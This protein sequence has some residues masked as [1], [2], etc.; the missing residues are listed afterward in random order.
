MHLIPHFAQLH[1]NPIIQM[2]YLKNGDQRVFLT[3]LDVFQILELI[4]LA[5]NPR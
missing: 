2:N 1:Q 3:V 4:A 5:Y